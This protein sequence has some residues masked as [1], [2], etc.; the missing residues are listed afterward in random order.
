MNQLKFIDLFAGIGGFH[1]ALAKLG[2]K[3]VFAC[4][5][6]KYARMIYENY[7]KP[8]NPEVF[9]SN[10]AEDIL[11]VSH[12]AIPDFDLLTAGFPCQPFSQAGKKLGFNEARG[13]LFFEIAKLIQAKQPKA[14]LLENVRNLASH[15]DGKTLNVIKNTLLELGYSFNAKVLRASAYGLPTHR[16]RI[17]IV[18][19]KDQSIKFDF[20]EP[21]PLKFTMSD[22]FKGEC[23]KTIGYTLRV[24]G[25]NSGLYDRRNWDTYLVNN[26]PHTITVEE[27]KLMMGFPKEFS[28]DLV[29]KTQAQKQLGNSVAIDVIEEIGKQIIKYI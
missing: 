19:F 7:F 23:N 29:S 14:F 4:E 2:M 1:L 10:F 15:D 21:I 17:Y 6:D 9:E 5:I 16:P 18:G 25:K 20:P 28:F 13:T 12:D 11:N 3:C 27:S 24:G 8:H 26:T 22:I